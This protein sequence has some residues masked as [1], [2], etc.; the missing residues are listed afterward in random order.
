LLIGVA[1]VVLLGV[2]LVVAAVAGVGWLG[3]K[4]K[5]AVQSEQT[6][7]DQTHIATRPVYF[8]PSHPPQYDV[9][10]RPVTCVVDADGTAVATGTV[11]NRSATASA[12]FLTVDFARG[13]KDV[14]S[15]GDAVLNV[16]P[17]QVAPWRALDRRPA[18]ASASGPLA[19]TV[20]AIWRWNRPAVVPGS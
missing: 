12:Y 14:G 11:V 7:E 13:G 16:G 18:V 9:W 6:V 15:G 4:A 2:A 20:S 8:D 19:C 1:V 3:H 10:K 5:K 17:G